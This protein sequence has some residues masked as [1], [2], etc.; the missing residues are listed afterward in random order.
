MRHISYGVDEDGLV[1]SRV[2]SQAACPVL[3]F[4]AI[5]QGGDG[6]EPG[7]FTGPTRFTLEKCTLY[8]LRH[9]GIR[10]T[11]H[12]PLEVK[13]AHRRFWG[14]P[15]LRYEVPG[16]RAERQPARQR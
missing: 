3:D 7:D 5:G 1:Y 11:R 10:W 2:G 6:F 16:Y 9:E 12:V 4:E 15:E 14:F 13:N 8:E